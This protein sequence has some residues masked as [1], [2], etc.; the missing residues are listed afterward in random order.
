M[1]N[2]FESLLKTD[3]QIV[4]NLQSND[5]VLKYSKLKIRNICRAL[6]L[7]AT[8]YE[9]A[10]TVSAIQDYLREK[11]SKERILYSE[12]SS[13]VYGLSEDEQGNFGTNVESLLAFV[14]DET[15]KVEDDPCKIVIKIYDHFQL[16]INQKNLNSETNDIVSTHIADKVEKTNDLIEKTSKDVKNVEKEYITI[17]GIFASIVLAF[18]GGLTFSTSVLQNINAISIYRLLIVVDLIAVVLVNVIYLMMKFIC[19]INEK[20][21]KVFNIVWFNIIFAIIG[22]LVIVA[23]AIDF[24]SLV[25]FIRCHLPWSK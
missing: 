19:H 24:N 12:I 13:F 4:N 22:I 2:N 11:A 21:G 3:G 25:D 15:N 14:V 8:K 10:K 5:D 18:V 9:P 7:P 17:L 20:K 16:A 1:D 23:W 6:C